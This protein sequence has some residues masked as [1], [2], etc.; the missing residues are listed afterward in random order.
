MRTE[1]CSPR[2][3][4][5]TWHEAVAASQTRFPLRTLEASLQADGSCVKLQLLS[6]GYEDWTAAEQRSGANRAPAAAVLAYLMCRVRYGEASTLSLPLVPAQEAALE[7]RPGMLRALGAQSGALAMMMA[8]R[9]KDG[10]S[11]EP[12]AK[13]LLCGCRPHRKKAAELVAAWKETIDDEGGGAKS[14]GLF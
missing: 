12:G 9:G 10:P 2:W 6:D 1:P 5:Q 7:E 11:A 14:P 8:D 4:S 13:L 3:H